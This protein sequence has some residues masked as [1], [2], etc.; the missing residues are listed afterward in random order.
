M[1]DDVLLPVDGSDEAAEA[2][3][4]A[5]SIARATDATV[6][7][8]FVS[9]P[10]EF[11]L[12]GLDGSSLRS[13][14]HRRGR[15]QL[16]SVAARA[17]DAGVTLERLVRDGIPYEEIR[18]CA[19]DVGADLIVMGTRGLATDDEARVGSTTERVIA[20][21]GTPVLAVPIG[22]RDWADD[23]ENGPRRILVP[24]DG[25][26][27]AR[28]AG[29]HAVELAWQFGGVV[30]TI[31]VIDT[32]ALDLDRAPDSV[33]ELLR[34]GSH[35]VTETVASAARKRDVAVTVDV[36]R[37]APAAE[38][39]AAVDE[40]DADLIVMGSRGRTASADQFLG[41]TTGRVLLRTDRLVL[42]VGPSGPE[43]TPSG[44]LS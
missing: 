5:L 35:D 21:A 28:R 30:E 37:G 17:D 25:S 18:D 36:R 10:I 33:S 27:A 32:D 42:T 44:N 16:A 34:E 11:E 39:L 26:D 9:E 8:L 31:H 3:L 22:A 24:T 38:I 41:S 6:H 29:E 1:Y 20:F 19:E 2:V 4:R 43:S 40:S 23:G 7:A 14:S 13:A 12:P 15:A